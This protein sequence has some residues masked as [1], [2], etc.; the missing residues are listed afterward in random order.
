M[1]KYIFPSL[2]VFVPCITHAYIGPGM[3]GGIVVATAGFFIAIF[4]ALLSV[5]YYPVKRWIKGRKNNQNE[6]NDEDYKN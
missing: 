5:I 6:R 3:A 4:I 2:L 1:I